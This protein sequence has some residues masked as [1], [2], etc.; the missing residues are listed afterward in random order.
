MGKA[1]DATSDSRES[2][3]TIPLSVVMPTYNEVGAIG[4]VVRSW[5][6][7][8]DELAIGYELRLYDDG[9]RDGTAQVA[10]DAAAGHP[11]F[12]LTRQEN[13]GHGPT[14]LR[15]YAEARGEWVFQVDS[16]GEMPA[17]A[18]AEF[19][20]AR[21]DCDLLLGWRQGRQSNWQRRVIT[22]LAAQ[23]VRRLFGDA[24]RDVNCPYRL[25]RAERLRQALVLVPSDTFAPNVALTGLAYRLR[26]R[27]EERPVPYRPRQTGQP[28][29]VRWRLWRAAVRSLLQTIA[30]ARRA[31]RKGTASRTRT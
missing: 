9:S 15:G 6:A 10:E 12:V 7:A 30:I 29:I 20:R 21:H 2:E 25:F 5:L 4:G 31:G 14:I 18:F 23:T 11:A 22:A 28:S 3:P 16:D 19:W 13:S 1:L 8:L 17:D 24:P 26:W 27:V